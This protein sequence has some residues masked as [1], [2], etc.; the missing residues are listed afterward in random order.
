MTPVSHQA[1]Q[2][3]S[4]RKRIGNSISVDGVGSPKHV[5]ELDCQFKEEQR[6]WE[7]RVR[8]ME[9][10][11]RRLRCKGKDDKGRHEDESSIDLRC[12]VVINGVEGV[13]EGVSPID[14]S[15]T[16]ISKGGGLSE[17][18][19]E[20]STTGLTISRGTPA[21]SCSQKILLLYEFGVLGQRKLLSSSVLVFGTGGIGSTL[22]LFL[23]ASVMRRITVVDHDNLEVSNLHWQVMHTEG[24]RG[25]SKIIVLEYAYYL[26][27]L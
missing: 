21:R 11:M 14:P 18:S 3:S 2:Y 12:D 16:S 6:G 26:S 5:E 27:S 4:D 20:D 9:E 1:P 23:A 7:R 25:T 13:E 10:E 17:Y 24:R 22:L 8:D 19:G 15:L